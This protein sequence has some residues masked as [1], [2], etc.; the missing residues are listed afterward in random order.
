MKGYT[1]KE[2]NL[3]L[4]KTLVLGGSRVALFV[5][6]LLGK[7]SEKLILNPIAE[8]RTGVSH[9]E[10]KQEAIGVAT[11][12]ENEQANKMQPEIDE[13]QK[14]VDNW[15]RDERGNVK[16]HF[17]YRAN[18]NKLAGLLKKQA[19]RR[20]KPRIIMVAAAYVQLMRIKDK[21]YTEQLEREYE[22]DM[23]RQK[24]DELYA[25]ANSA[26]EQHNALD[27]RKKELEEEIASIGTKKELL[28]KEHA[29]FL[30]E[31]DKIRQQHSNLIG[32]GFF[33]GATS[34]LEEEAA[35][36]KTM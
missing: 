30:Q 10:I 20:A 27:V 35:Q 18:S 34:T 8:I 2:F 23:I 7:I 13:G 21:Q 22:E 14:M 1:N 36:V 32:D 6:R 24:Y 3:G 16:N 33:G 15:A 11:R 5:P 19:K 12:Y 17:W 25:S 28:M 31:M 4:G 29:Y 9:E 26:L